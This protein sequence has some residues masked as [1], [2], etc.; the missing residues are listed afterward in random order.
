VAPS[1][2]TTVYALVE[3]EMPKDGLYRSDDGGKTWKQ[4]D[5]SQNMIWRPFYFANLIVAPK[6]GNKIYKPDGP[7]IA[8]SD[9]GRSFSNISG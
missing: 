9:G 1:K 6:N 4:L 3:A 7:L 5:R 8:S 2:P